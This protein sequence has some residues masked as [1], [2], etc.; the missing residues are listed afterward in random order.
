MDADWQKNVDRSLCD[1]NLRVTER[2]VQSGSR[3]FPPLAS[4]R[5]VIL[6]PVEK[7]GAGV[8]AIQGVIQSACLIHSWHDG[9][10]HLSHHVPTFVGTD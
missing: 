3:Y 5:S 1:R 7:L 6:L 2:L 8:S 9:K 4:E 10:W